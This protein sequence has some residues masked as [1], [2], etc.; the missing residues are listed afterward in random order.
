[1]GRPKTLTNAKHVSMHM[2][3]EQ[4]DA[5]MRIAGKR[6]AETGQLVTF[7]DLLR[8]AINAFIALNK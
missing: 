7:S 8:E 6:Q 2:E 5:L 4:K 3:D 1:M